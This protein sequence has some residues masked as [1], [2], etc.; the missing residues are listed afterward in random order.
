MTKK[1]KLLF[2]VCAL[3]FLIVGVLLKAYNDPTFMGIFF[4]S[5][6]CLMLFMAIL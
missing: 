5:I 2:I 1:Q 6:G 4:I 3:L